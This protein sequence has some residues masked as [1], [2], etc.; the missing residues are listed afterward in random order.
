VLNIHRGEHVDAVLGKLEDVLV[1][2]AVS[3]AGCIR[4]RQLVHQDQ[5]RFPRDNGVDVHL[6]ERLSAVGQ[7]HAGNELEAGG[8]GVRFFPLVA[9]Q[10]SDDDVGSFQPFALR[11][12]EHRKGLAD[13]R[14]HAEKD[15]DLSFSLAALFNHLQKSVGIGSS[16]T[17]VGQLKAPWRG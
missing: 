11:L 6:L 2:L 17:V 1:A 12:L 7:R 9:L 8:E 10:V 3:R 4:V 16:F 5:L 15:L 14:G 13:P